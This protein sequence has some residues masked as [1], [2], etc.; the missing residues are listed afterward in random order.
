MAPA[1]VKRFARWRLWLAE[2]ICPRGYAP[3]KNTRVW[4]YYDFWTACLEAA[5]K[6]MAEPSP[7]A[8]QSGTLVA[9]AAKNHFQLWESHDER[10]RLGADGD[11][12]FL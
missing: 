4:F 10:P 7:V 6:G 9:W 5:N 1:P 2:K 12:V 11:N 3:Q 8:R